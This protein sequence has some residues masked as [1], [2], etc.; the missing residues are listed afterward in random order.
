MTPTEYFNEVYQAFQIA[1]QRTS[2]ST[3]RFFE[4]GGNHVRFRFA[5]SK[6]V[7]LIAPAFAHLSIEQT[8]VPAL[9][10]CLWDSE[11]TQTD[12][13]P[14]R[15]TAEARQETG[16]IKVFC[17]DHIKVVEVNGTDSLILYDRERRFGIYWK[18]NI[19]QFRSWEY[20]SP[21]REL[22]HLWTS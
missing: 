1:E 9:T 14:R 8:S 19:S 16:E 2:N 12:L 18:Q 11:S 21:L 3:E 6:L 17:N 22:L 7:S 10:I 13:P 4:I 15:W 20:A 5:G